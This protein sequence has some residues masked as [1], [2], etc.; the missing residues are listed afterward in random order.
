MTVNFNKKLIFLAAVIVISA[1]GFVQSSFAYDTSGSFTSTNLLSGQFVISIDSIIYNLSSKP[2]NTS[3]SIQFSQN[4]T[5]WYS[6]AGVENASDTLT[7]GTNNTIDLS[8]LLWTGANFY[9][10]VTL[11]SDG[12]DTPVLDDIT[13]NYTDTAGANITVTATVQEYLSFTSSATSTTLSPDLVDSS[14]V[15]HIASSSEITLTINTSSADGYSVTVNGAGNGLDSGGNYI[16]TS[17]ATAT[18]AAGTDAFGIQAT[19]TTSGL[20]I[21]SNFAWPFSGTIIGSASSST[22]VMLASETSPGANQTFT[23]RFL[24]ASDAAQPSGSYTDTIVLTAVP[25]P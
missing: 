24:A 21:D 22:P 20:T 5:N 8:G 9:Y 23:I 1:F 19:T 15:T 17:S 11:T 18:V 3:A 2:A 12:S 13:L 10:K 6:S 14:G 25:T 4:S 7:T 16:Y